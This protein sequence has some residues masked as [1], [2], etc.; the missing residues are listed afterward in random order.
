M[1]NSLRLRR[2]VLPEELLLVNGER[3]GKRDFLA[4]AIVAPARAKDGW[5]R[6][7]GV[8]LFMPAPRLSKALQALRRGAR[9]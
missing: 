3:M 1:E 9:P 6:T 7:P 2:R 5:P 8:S 4:C